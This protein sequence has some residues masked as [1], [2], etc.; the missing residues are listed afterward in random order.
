M[1]DAQFI[2]HMVLSLKPKKLYSPHYNLLFD[3]IAILSEAFCVL[4]D[5]FVDACNIP[6]WVLLFN[7]L[8]LRGSQLIM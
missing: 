5:E 4:S 2:L 8:P 6:C 7:S 1:G 3:I